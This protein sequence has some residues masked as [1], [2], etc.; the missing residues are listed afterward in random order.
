MRFLLCVVSFVFLAACGATSTAPVSLAEP[1][2]RYSFVPDVDFR[3]LDQPLTG[4]PDVI[5][6]FYYGCRACYYLTDELADWSREGGVSLA[7]QPAH[8][9]ENLVDGARFFHTLAELKR[10]DLHVATYGLFQQPHELQGEER[11][12]AMLAA[13][14]VAQEEFWQAWGSE[15][16]NRRL[17]TSYQLTQLAGVSTTPSFIVR[18]KYVVEMP[19]FDGSEKILALLDHLLQL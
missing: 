14:D 19:V 3:E 15:A 17:A 13:N 2:A 8:G 4:A 5:E 7:L 12:N 11:I 9:E 18:G 10:L 1:A 16:V 6:L